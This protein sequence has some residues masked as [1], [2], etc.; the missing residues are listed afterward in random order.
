MRSLIQVD[1]ECLTVSDVAERLKLNPDTVRR[2]FRDEPGVI[3]ISCPRKGRRAYRTLRIPLSVYE[4]V[5]L[6]MT[7]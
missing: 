5:V 1:E 4:R 3:V 2:L 7:Q 6:R